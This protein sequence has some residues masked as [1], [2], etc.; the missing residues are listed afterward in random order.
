MHTM[1]GKLTIYLM[2]S[3]LFVTT[4]I[5]GISSMRISHMVTENRGVMLG[6]L[7]N[8]MANQLNKDMQSRGNEVQMLTQL[9]DIKSPF[10]TNQEKLAIFEQLR[11]SYP[12]YA[13]IGMTDAS[14][15]ILV[16]TDGLLVGKNVSK[17]S[18]FIHGSKGLHMG[19]VH[20]AFL[21]ANIMPKPK[22]DDLPLRLVDV[23][24]PILDENGQLLGVICGHLGWDWA[25]E[26]REELLRS[27]TLKNVDILV[28]K[29]DGSLL[30]GTAELPSASINLSSLNSFQNALQRQ[31]GL[32]E[33]RWANGVEYLS[34]ARYLTTPENEML[35]WGVVARE[36]V[37]SV[38]TPAYS[39]LVNSIVILVLMM[40]LLWL[41]VWKI[42][43]R[44]TRALEDLTKVA[45]RIRHGDE[46]ADISP[47]ATNDSEVGMLSSSIGQ[48]VDSLQQEVRA[49]TELA[50]E[51]Q[52]MARIYEESPQGVMITDSQ[53]N[54]LSVNDAFTTVTGY[55]REDVLGKSPSLLNSNRHS[56]E[57][58]R[59]MWSCILNEGRWQGEIWNRNKSGEVYPEWL[60]VST[61]KNKQNEVTH[62]IGIFSDISEKIENEKQ[63]EFL[64]NHDVL[65]QLP[66]RR[67]L[68]DYI[69]QAL[70]SNETQAGLIFLD[71]D[72]FKAINDSL[73]HIVG[74]ELLRQVA[75]ALNNQFKSPNLVARF[76]GDEFVIFMPQVQTKNEL[77]SAV[78]QVAELF[79]APY[80]VGDYTLQIG[81]TMGV[82]VY[83]VDGSDAQSLIQ[84]ADTAMYD[85][86][87]NHLN[88]YQ[89]Y[90]DSMR[91]AAIKKLYFE[92]DLKNA[93]I[94]Q[95]LFLVYQP[96][97]DL[98]TQ[99]LVG[100]ET[101]LRW[102]H[103]QRGVVSPS[104]FVPVL[105]KMGLIE[106]VGLWVVREALNQ[107]TTWS[108]AYQLEGV[109]ISINLS[110]IQ[111]RSPKFIEDIEAI[112]QSSQ[113][114]SQSIVF[115][116]TESMMVEDN[117]RNNKVF[118]SIQNMGC[119]LSLDDYGT[120]YSNLYYLDRLN[121][122]ELKIDR[123]FILN[124]DVNES[125]RLIV[126]HTIQMAQSLGLH[127][128]IEGIET[129]VQLEK[130]AEYSN[131]IIQGYYFDKPLNQAE[132]MQ[133]LEAR[134]R[135]QH[136]P[137]KS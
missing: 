73:G 108:A 117:F 133:R 89:F 113:V 36:S 42:V 31:Q 54:I 13:W 84:A 97:I 57:F 41:L 15:N 116:V 39:I 37:R 79:Q 106:E 132:L 1:R 28:T 136:W 124:I 50:N 11:K 95:E 107:F 32:A 18:W 51:L 87:K 85:V 63:L 82:S 29:S 98:K 109:S 70:D 78:Q 49:K 110:A 111:L 19:S 104:E 83:P 74:D 91:Q 123:Q 40:L 33:E 75:E 55:E 24:A 131:L 60:V 101:L 26:M 20:D 127:V 135:I 62:Y 130:L 59:G 7:A 23:S 86:K 119:R 71:L 17:R 137:Q 128:V 105:E 125:D 2:L 76:G 8:H 46:K 56:S 12:Y 99:N 80:L 90:N 67:L 112:I 134:K 6:E 61:L 93:L 65:T 103:P 114:D 3:V 53:K 81:A 27:D 120:G 122:S 66:N 21:L 34:A 25:F 35:Q 69:N 68:Q 126:H 77:E 52:L 92:N 94:N 129:Q 72:F 45:D 47:Y 118:E 121:L 30:M 96:Q 64:A 43:S 44:S 58:Y 22:W 88:S 4:V 102:T 38:I 16:G 9:S 14:G 100:F 10:T 48:L 5:A 115:E